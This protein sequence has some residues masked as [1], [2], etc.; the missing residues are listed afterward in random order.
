VVSGQWSV[1]SGQEEAISPAKVHGLDA[2]QLH[3][4]SLRGRLLTSALGHD[5]KSF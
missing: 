5:P 4:L 3:I 2:A 1:V